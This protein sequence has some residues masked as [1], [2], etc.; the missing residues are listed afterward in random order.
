MKYLIYFTTLA[1]GFIAPATAD[2]DLVSACT[3]TVD[4]YAVYRDALDADGYA[5]LFTEDA[6]FVTPAKTFEG[7]DEI[8]AYIKKQPTSFGTLHHITTRQIVALNRAGDA[9]VIKGEGIIYVLVNFH[10]KGEDNKNHLFRSA[11]AVYTDQYRFSDG[12]CE[13]AHRSLK[14]LTDT[15]I[16]K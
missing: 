12:T 6:A 4:N 14:I 15:Y 8:R 11:Q 7:R 2:E 10:Q 13:I 9:A 3:K 1:F 5:S 16:S